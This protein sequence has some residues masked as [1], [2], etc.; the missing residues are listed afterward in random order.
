LS[1]KELQSPVELPNPPEKKARASREV[2]TDCALLVLLTASFYLLVL[3]RQYSGD[4]VRYLPDLAQASPELGMNKHVMFPGLFWAAVNAGRW[5]GLPL[6]LGGTFERPGVLALCQSVNALLGALGVLGLYLWQRAAGGQRRT[7]LLLSLILAL[8][9]AYA[10]HATDMTEPIAAV[11]WLLGG[12]AFF[13][14]YPTSLG[15]VLAGGFVGVAASFYIAAFLGCAL[16]GSEAIA[17][18][19]RTHSWA[20]AL[21]VAIEIVGAAVGSYLVVFIILSSVLTQE[22]HL[23]QVLRSTLHFTTDQGLF[24]SLNP[25]HLVGAV[26][27]FAN[28]WVPLADFEGVS[29][30]FRTS[31]TQLL[32]NLAIVSSAIAV[33]LGLAA[34]L[35]RMRRQLVRENLVGDALGSLTW[36]TAVFA[37]AA[38]WGPTYEKLWLFGAIATLCL[39]S[40]IFDR[41]A[42]SVGSR[43]RWPIVLLAGLAVASLAAGILPRRF[44]QNRDLQGAAT[45]ATRLSESDLLVCPGWDPT[46]VYYK[47]LSDPHRKCWAIV[48]NAIAAKFDATTVDTALSNEI[49]DALQ[50]HR[51][52]FFLGLLDAKAVEWKPFYEERLRLPFVLLRKYRDHSNPAFVVPSAKG[53]DQAVFRYCG[54]AG[55]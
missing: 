10:L 38:F 24:G 27:G 2:L 6:V 16:L 41:P 54:D 32:Y 55:C 51:R 50:S 14:R 48:D 40:A 34:R 44:G 33:V 49:S 35:W 19:Q 20:S 5:S 26:F 43:E 47:T 13:R 1:T 12:A 31:T 52:V 3:S 29:R 39:V 23:G 37:L 8:S 36:L 21:R 22:A 30:L 25:K 28:A 11:P 46:S 15:A 18:Y 4:G 17:R 7:A 9:N 42:I 53:G 45:L